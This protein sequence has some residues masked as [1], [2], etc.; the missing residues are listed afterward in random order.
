MNWNLIKK[1]SMVVS[2]AGFMALFN[3]SQDILVRRISAGIMVISVF[4]FFI[5][6]IKEKRD[7]K[8]NEHT[9]IKN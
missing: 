9:Q 1:I 2:F 6:T 4:I 3:P 7:K 5:L 8:K